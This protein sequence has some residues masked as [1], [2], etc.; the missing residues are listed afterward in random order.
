MFKVFGLR[1]NVEGG[2]AR[3][4]KTFDT[5]VLT[6]VVEAVDLG[7]IVDAGMLVLLNSGAV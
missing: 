2:T 6:L 4:G 3:V 5:L 7:S 1:V